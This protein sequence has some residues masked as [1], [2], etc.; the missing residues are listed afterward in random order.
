[1]HD[2]SAVAMNARA[3]RFIHSVRA[4]CTD[5]LLPYNEQHARRVLAEYAGHDDSRR[6]HRT[7]QL[8]APADAPDDIPLPVQRIQ[9]HE[10][11]SGLVHEYRDTP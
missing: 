4:G 10:V 8:R 7:L 11:L 3:E 1:M 5:R 2:P 9:R 6:P